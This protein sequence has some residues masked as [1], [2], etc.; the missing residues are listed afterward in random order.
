MIFA[1]VNS[2]TKVSDFQLSFFGQQQV[3]TFDISMDYIELV[4]VVKSFKNLMNVQFD[5]GLGKKG[6]FAEMTQRPSFDVL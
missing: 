1:D 3:E 4:Q 6:S 5:E 2:H